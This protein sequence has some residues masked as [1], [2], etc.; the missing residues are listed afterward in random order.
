LSELLNTPIDK[1]VVAPNAVASCFHPAGEEAITQV[2]ERLRL[3]RPYVLA[4]GSLQPR[5]NLRRLL[6]AWEQLGSTTAGL[7]L[8]VAGGEFRVF[9]SAGLDRLPPR[10]RLL[11]YVAESDLV[12][13]Y[14]GAMLFC[15]PSLYE[16]FGMPP[17][18]AMACGTPVITSNTTSL[19]E[20][21]GD[22]ALLVN[23]LEID[24][25]A[26]ALRQLI[27][28]ADLR[29]TLRERGL[30]RSRRFDW[31]QTTQIVWNVLQEAAAED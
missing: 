20:V 6:D 30:R 15:Y 14:S 24:S 1:I 11:G 28:D 13:L 23:P 22:A 21:V 27:E 26:V 17:L 25:I 5:K 7:E 12:P 8:V 19:P 2:K 31:D 3:D 4:V 29:S 10:V 16:G 18:E 9:S